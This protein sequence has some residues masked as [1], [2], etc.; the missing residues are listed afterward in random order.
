MEAVAAVRTLHST[1]TA[2]EVT[3]HAETEAVALVVAEE[4]V[5]RHRGH[6][7]QAGAVPV[8]VDLALRL[9]QVSNEGESVI[10]SRVHHPLHVTTTL[11]WILRHQERRFLCKIMEIINTASNIKITKEKNFRS[12]HPN[13][14]LSINDGNLISCCS[15]YKYTFSTTISTIQC[16]RDWTVSNQI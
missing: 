16:F 1:V 14:I 7:G 12:I 13:H 15:F 6:P 11:E 5:G 4:L 9:L 8:V 3:T 10:V 2:E